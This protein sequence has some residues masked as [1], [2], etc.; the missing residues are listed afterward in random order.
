[1]RSRCD[2]PASREVVRQGAESRTV[3]GCEIP[4]Q[5]DL[6]AEREAVLRLP[7]SNG[8]WVSATPGPLPWPCEQPAS[9]RWSGAQASRRPAQGADSQPRGT[10]CLE[11]HNA[12]RPQRVHLLG[13]GRQAGDHPRTPYSPDSGGAG[14][15]SAPALLLAGV[16]A[17]RAHRQIAAGA[18][19]SITCS[20]RGL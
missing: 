10:R 6:D 15:R 7:A 16:Q 8:R 14:G 12:S 3:S 18:G 11:G 1:M 20:V 4:Q 5:T 2:P 17:P 19:A 13:R 9:T